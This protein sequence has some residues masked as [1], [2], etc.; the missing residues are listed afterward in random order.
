MIQVLI[1]SITQQIP[2]LLNNWTWW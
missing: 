1:Q 2:E